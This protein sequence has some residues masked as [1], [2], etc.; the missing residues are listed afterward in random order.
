MFK[1][2][3]FLSVY[4][5]EVAQVCLCLVYKT[6][7]FNQSLFY[8]AW[9]R[10]TNSHSLS[11]FLIRVSVSN[12]L[13]NSL[14]HREQI[15]KEKPSSQLEFIIILFALYLFLWLKIHFWQ[16]ILVSIYGRCGSQP[17]RWPPRVS[18]QSLPYY[19]RTGLCG[20]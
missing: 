17:P 20:L 6:R 15:S 14:T 10:T 7:S 13:V 18:V 1:L 11:N 4:Q 5:Y 3:L 19:T 16:M 8:K 2:K 9:T 12:H